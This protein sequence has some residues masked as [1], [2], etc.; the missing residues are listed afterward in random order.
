MQVSIAM[1]TYN[2]GAFLKEQLQ[3][4]A[5]QAR[6]PDELVVC[7]D[8][9]TDDTLTIVEA[10]A[11]GAPFPVIVERNPANLGYTANFSKA[12]SGCT[13]DVIFLSDQDDRWYPGKIQRVMQVMSGGKAVVTN[14]SQ[15][16]AADGTAW[17]T[18][19]GNLKALGLSDIEL[20]NGSCTAMSRAFANLALPFPSRIPFD[21]WVTMLGIVLEVRAVIEEPLQIYR[22]HGANT[23][24]PVAARR[25]PTRLDYFRLHGFK[26]PRPGWA[27]EIE[28]AA[29]CAE[30]IQERRELAT[31]LAGPDAV[32]AALEK[33]KAMRDRY[34]RRLEVI[35]RPR[36]RRPGMILGLWRS[37]F[38]NDFA[39]WKSA[40]K[41]LARP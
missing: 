41:D 16:V 33:L 34:R 23:S 19:L 35:A 7:D 1:A 13:G 4:F 31:A 26:D 20:T 27:F 9:S 17:G 36:S 8:G 30:R 15:L 5:D 39:G 11:A 32:A 25:K 37:G 29:T 10:F 14:N 24:Q 2:G 40:A 22:R 6:R 18:T 21:H 38:Y 28:F 12:A 3:S